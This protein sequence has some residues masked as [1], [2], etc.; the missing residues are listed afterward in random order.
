MSHT[1]TG[2]GTL[3]LLPEL[4]LSTAYQLLRPYFILDETFD[5]VTPLF[6]GATPGATQF[7]PTR[8][9][10]PHLLMEKSMVGIPPVKPGDY[11]FWHCDLVHEVDKFHP[12]TRDS[13]VSYN[14]CVPLC[15]Y[16]LENLVGMRQ[17]FLDVLPP[18][19]HANYPHNELERDHADHGA[20]RENILSLP[21]LRALGLAPFDVDEEGLTP[22]QR[23]MR[24]LANER[25]GFSKTSEG[26]AE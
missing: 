14:G 18:N 5:E 9:L 24:Q 19:D 21:G 16:N 15:P 12:G 2:E 17:S 25:L 11:V 26:L 6:P 7:L 23:R 3:R 22:G 20:R 8:D 4:K 10:H 13:S 1:N